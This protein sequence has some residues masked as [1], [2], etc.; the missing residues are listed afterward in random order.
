[1][2]D[3]LTGQTVRIMS[4]EEITEEYGYDR[5]DF[6][7]GIT[8]GGIG[9]GADDIEYLGNSYTVVES[10]NSDHTVRLDCAVGW[11]PNEILE[12]ISKPDEL[13][14]FKVG[15]RVVFKSVEDMVADGSID[16]NYFVEPMEDLCGLEATI[17]NIRPNRSVRDSR[18]AIVELDKGSEYGDWTYTTGMFEH[19]DESLAQDINQDDWI[20]ILSC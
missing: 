16:W 15:D 5:D 17:V 1:M 4:L 19:V 6:E 7:N 9:L 18:M 11:W 13:F 14:G 8:I 10:D 2:A 3:I 20:G 12:V